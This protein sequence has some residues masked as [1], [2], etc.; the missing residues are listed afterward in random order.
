MYIYIYYIY[1]SHRYMCIYI[2]ILR[3]DYIM[4]TYIYMHIIKKEVF[5]TKFPPAGLFG[6]HLAQLPLPE[7]RPGAHQLAP[8]HG[9]ARARRAEDAAAGAGGL[10]GGGKWG[11]GWM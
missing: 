10:G 2:Y 8:A 9:A 3:D 6:R 1:I 7:L 5:E 11:V 4:D